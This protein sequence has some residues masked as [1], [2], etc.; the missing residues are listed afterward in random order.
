MTSTSSKNLDEGLLQE[1]EC[2]VCMEYMVP[3]IILCENGHNICFNC[4]SRLKNCPT[5]RGLILQARNLALENLSRQIL[6]PCVFRRFGCSETFSL[7]SITA[8][9]KSCP[10]GSYYCP[11]GSSHS[12]KCE[13]K[14]P[15]ANLLNHIGKSHKHKLFKNEVVKSKLLDVHP[16]KEYSIA[17]HALG[18]IFYF[19]FKV[20]DDNFY[21]YFV[22]IGKYTDNCFKC[23]ISFSK[24]DSID[25]ITLCSAVETAMEGVGSCDFEKSI[26]LH[27]SY[28]SRFVD[29][30]LSLEFSIEISQIS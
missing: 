10:H 27:Y 24:V 7:E 15:L 21:I 17:I 8:H 4:K 6:Y 5:C 18:E 22:H 30:E 2:P 23:D 9:Q 3:P 11:F 1:L 14:G 20:A 13:W 19:Q 29:E 12:I 26:K 25:K 28:I 16:G